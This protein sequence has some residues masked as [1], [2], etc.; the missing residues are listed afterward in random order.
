[1][2]AKDD[3]DAM[4]H[5]LLVLL[6]L[7]KNRPEERRLSG[8]ENFANGTS[9]RRW[10]ISSRMHSLSSVSHESCRP[11]SA[12]SDVQDPTQLAWNVAGKEEHL[13]QTA[14]GDDAA[15]QQVRRAVQEAGPWQLQIYE[16]HERARP[17]ARGAAELF[18]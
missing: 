9:P 1:M 4:R 10:A 11:R 8:V 3:L 6:D 12:A 14:R 7:A 15:G 5:A 18:R 2:L 16:I 13:A 17:Q